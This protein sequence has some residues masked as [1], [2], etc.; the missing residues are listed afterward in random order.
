M[1][2]SATQIPPLSPSPPID[3]TTVERQQQYKRVG[4]KLTVMNRRDMTFAKAYFTAV[5]KILCFSKGL[6]RLCDLNQ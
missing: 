3:P 4:F 5:A 6:F 1:L 2:D